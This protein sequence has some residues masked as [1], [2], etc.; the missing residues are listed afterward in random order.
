MLFKKAE[1]PVTMDMTRSV[2]RLLLSPCFKTNCARVD[3]E[4]DRWMPAITINKHAIV[5]TLWFIN[6]LARSTEEMLPVINR[7][8]AA[9]KKA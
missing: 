5:T 1:N 3:I 7:M 2:N 8:T 6:P 9:P 4:V